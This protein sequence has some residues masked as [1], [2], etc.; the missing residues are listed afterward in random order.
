MDYNYNNAVRQMLGRHQIGSFLVSAF[1]H[2]FC[3]FLPNEMSNIKIAIKNK[4]M[5]E[6]E[7]PW[8]LASKYEMEL[9][10]CRFTK[11]K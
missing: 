2:V 8:Q 10:E 3:I 1:I 5:S 9:Y 11:D 6:V 4:I 7:K